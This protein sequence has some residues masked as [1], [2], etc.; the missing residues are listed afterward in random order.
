MLVQNTTATIEDLTVDATNNLTACGQDPI[1]ILYQNASGTITRN[2]VLHVQVI[3]GFGCQG[4][5]GIYV[6]SGATGVA[7]PIPRAKP[8]PPFPSLTTMCRITTRTG[9]QRTAR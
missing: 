9:S 6:E 2:N 3:N 7:L 1:G 8:T 4:G 5:L